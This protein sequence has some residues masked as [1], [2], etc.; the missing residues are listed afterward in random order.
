M[1]ATLW[2]VVLIKDF[3]TA[4]S[5]LATAM[6]PE[7]RRVL[8]VETAGRALHAALGVAPTLAV[9]GSA[10]AAD[11]ARSLDATVVVES[12][13]SG[14]NPAARLGLAEA[15]NRGAGAALLLSS[16]LPLV[17]AASLRRMLDRADGSENVIVA[18]AAT[19]RQGTNALFLRPP[20]DF[21]LHFGEASLPRFAQE[22]QRRGRRFI[23]HEDPT[24]A[25]DLDEPSDL[26]AWRQ[27]EPTA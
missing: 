8:A 7:A 20:G 26:V 15:S 18:A 5:R 12:D 11:L 19:G 4:K 6:E 3:R 24:L 27:L 17:D 16:D 13:P 23:L 22:A 2:I 9:C 1:P 10:E 21:D 14:Q 25:L